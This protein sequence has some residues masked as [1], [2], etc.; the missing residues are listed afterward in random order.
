MVCPSG[1]ALTHSG[2][3]V[4]LRALGVTVPVY[5]VRVHSDAGRQGARVEKGTSPRRSRPCRKISPGAT[6]MPDFHYGFVR[7]E[8]L[9]FS[10]GTAG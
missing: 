10:L 1:S 2:T 9:R 7:R 6:S 3:L 8:A 4:G 5:G